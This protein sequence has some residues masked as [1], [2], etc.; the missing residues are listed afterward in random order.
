MSP[1]KTGLVAQDIDT[2]LV[3]GMDPSSSELVCKFNLNVMPG[4]PKSWVVT[5]VKRWKMMATCC[6]DLECDF[7]TFS[8]LPV[9]A[10][11]YQFM[12]NPHES[13]SSTEIRTL[14]F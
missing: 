14:Y 1:P 5:D 11:R 4:V 8:F 12:L 10:A 9:F 2:S 3:V 13:P 7:L 6:G